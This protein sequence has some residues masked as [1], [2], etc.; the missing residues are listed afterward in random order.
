MQHG[1]LV[2]SVSCKA[3]QSRADCSSSAQGLKGGWMGGKGGGGE[4][5]KG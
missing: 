3:W 5:V 2:P 1:I 4:T